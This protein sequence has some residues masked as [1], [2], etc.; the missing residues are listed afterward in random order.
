MNL[1]LA[2]RHYEFLSEG[3]LRRLKES[4]KQHFALRHL[5]GPR[6]TPPLPLISMLAFSHNPIPGIECPS[7]RP[8]PLL[9]TSMEEIKNNIEI[10]GDPGGSN[11]D[12]HM[13]F[14]NL[15]GAQMRK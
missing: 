2:S 11:L 14:N 9:Q 13:N 4:I 10:W 1:A 12:D 15:G 5:I 3:K 6:R 8:A 7:Y